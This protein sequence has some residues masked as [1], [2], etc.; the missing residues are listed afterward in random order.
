MRLTLNVGTVVPEAGRRPWNNS[1]FTVGRRAVGALDDTPVEFKV[2][3]KNPEP[4]PFL[5]VPIGIG[6]FNLEGSTLVSRAR[7]RRRW[8]S[9]LP[10][11]CEQSN[12]RQ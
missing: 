8:R 1:L 9:D 7:P 11:P 3:L 5:L 12:W 6:T 4:K 10:C 2:E